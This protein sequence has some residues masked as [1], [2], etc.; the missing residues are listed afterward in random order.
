MHISLSKN[1]A[2]LPLPATKKW[3]D[4]VWDIEAFSHGTLSLL[5]FSPK[6]QDYQTPH[7]QDE[8][9]IAVNGHGVLEVEGVS[10]PFAEGDT[11]FVKAGDQHRFLEF[12]EDIKLWVV[13]Y[14]PKGGEQP[15]ID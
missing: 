12:S 5:L 11:L 8:I 1:L 15:L 13:L 6:G 2:K 4:G 10:F 7:D 9:Y 14:G 3:P